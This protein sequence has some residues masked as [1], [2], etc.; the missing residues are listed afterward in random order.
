MKGQGGSISIKLEG[1][2]LTS[3]H[4]EEISITQGDALKL[5]FLWSDIIWQQRFNMG[6]IYLEHLLKNTVKIRSIKK[7]QKFFSCAVEFPR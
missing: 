6:S 2:S 4:P 1:V 5:E 3:I 7:L